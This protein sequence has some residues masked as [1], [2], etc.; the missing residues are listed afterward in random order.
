MVPCI[1]IAGDH[2][3][4]CELTLN[5]PVH[6]F[7][8]IG[9]VEDDIFVDPQH[10]PKHALPS[11]FSD[12]GCAFSAGSAEWTKAKAID[13]RV[14]Q[15]ADAAQ[16]TATKT[17]NDI[18]ISRFHRPYIHEFLKLVYERYDIGIWSQ[19]S[20]RWIEIKLTELGMLT[21][22]GILSPCIL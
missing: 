22:P 19:T 4:L 2:V 11:V 5:T 21:T 1:Y 12:F 18:P 10:M 15:I 7:M 9:T 3:L 16:I 8:L 14:D 17:S 6:K 20:W 13:D